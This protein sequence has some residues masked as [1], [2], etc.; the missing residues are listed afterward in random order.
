ML[1][2]SAFIFISLFLVDM[3]VAQSS[4]EKAF[5]T[6]SLRIDFELGGNAE[7]EFAFFKEMKEEPYWAGNPEHLVDVRNSGDYRISMIDSLGKVQFSKGFN[8]LFK[9][10]QTTPEAQKINRSYYHAI[11]L[12][13]PKHT[14]QINIASRQKNGVFKTLLEWE[15]VPE[16]YLINRETTTIYPIDTIRFA[17][18]SSDFLD[19]VFI[20]EG[21]TKKEMK[22][23]QQD[24][25]RFEKYIFEVVPFSEFRDKVNIFA[26]LT[27]SKESSPDVPGEGIYNKTLLNSSFYTFDSPRYLT[28]MNE[29]KMYDLAGQ[30]PYDHIYVLV[31][32]PIYGGAGFY[33][34]YTSCASDATLSKE[35]SSHELG[36]GLVG[37]AD[38]YYANEADEISYFYTLDKEPW[39][40]NITSLADFGAKWKHLVAKNTPIPT[41]R[42]K[43]FEN[44]LGAFEGGA[45]Q[46]KGIYSPMQDCK[47]KSNN[48]NVFCPACV[49]AVRK[50][51]EEYTR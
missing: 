17:G 16:D 20:A 2:Y 6:K 38:E 21:Y 8:S 12:P 24:V 25:R 27:P 5:R 26:L 3:V 4:F 9:E 32:T 44:V 7:K 19:L 34:T 15:V 37:L 45:Y 42:I 41:P 1:R 50:V 22:K 47:M 43:K 30:M 40:K 29:K 31:N 49:E 14:M 48:T 11:Q 33:N 35:I 18:N 13:F 36:H 28:V 23:F 39:E 46:P 51:L 10:W